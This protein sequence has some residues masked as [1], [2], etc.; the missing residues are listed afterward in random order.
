MTNIDLSTLKKWKEQGTW[1]CSICGCT[2]NHA[3]DVG[4]YWVK[5]N[6]CSQC[7]SPEQLMIPLLEDFCIKVRMRVDFIQCSFED[8][9][10]EKLRLS[11]NG[12][13]NSILNEISKIEEQI[14][15]E[16][17]E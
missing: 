5:D 15:T 11:L 1:Q 12:S 16:V 17:A 8:Q 7:A 3:C 4:C 9:S 13:L 10:L 14:D 6:L 2:E